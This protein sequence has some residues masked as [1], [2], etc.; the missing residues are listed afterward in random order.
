MGKAAPGLQ[1]ADR[2]AHHF[3]CRLCQLCHCLNNDLSWYLVLII[4]ITTTT[5]II[6]III[7]IGYRPMVQGGRNE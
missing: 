2:E 6:V 5:I 4:T 1:L 7:I 3:A